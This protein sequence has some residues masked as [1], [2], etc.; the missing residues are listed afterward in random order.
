MGE[1]TDMKFYNYISA[2][3]VAMLFPTDRYACNECVYNMNTEHE[4]GGRRE[5][6]KCLADT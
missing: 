3:N 6:M 5:F 2:G 1:Y 4:N